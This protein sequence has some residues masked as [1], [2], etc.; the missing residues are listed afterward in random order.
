MENS[1][2]LSHDEIILVQSSLETYAEADHPIVAGIE[3]REPLRTDLICSSLQKLENISVLTYFSGKEISIMAA[4]VLFILQ[5]AELAP[6]DTE[7]KKE[8]DTLFRKLV[9][10]SDKKN[11]AH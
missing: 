10:I 3:F 9:A 2:N 7:D 4:A 1:L 11:Q 5:N 6:I 8:L